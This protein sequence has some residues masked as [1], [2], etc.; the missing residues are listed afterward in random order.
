MIKWIP[1]LI[2]PAKAKNKIPSR[3]TALEFV[4]RSANGQRINVEVAMTEKDA[5]KKLD[6]SKRFLTRTT[7]REKAAADNKIKNTLSTPT[8]NVIISSPVF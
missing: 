2:I 3:F 5:E 7:E 6:S 1:S 8:F 4:S